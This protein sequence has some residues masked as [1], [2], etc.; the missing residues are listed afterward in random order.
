MRTFLI[1]IVLLL[2]AVAGY[3][4]T[5]DPTG[6]AKLGTD[7]VAIFQTLTSPLPASNQETTPSS[8]NV[9]TATAPVSA[10]TPVPVPPLPALPPVKAWTPPAVIPA[11]PNWTWTTQDGSSYQNVVVTKIDPETVAITHSMGVAH[12]P[13]ATLPPDIQKLLNYDPEA[14]AAARAERKRELEH[15]YYDFD[16]LAEAQAVARQLHRPLAWIDSSLADLSVVN[17]VIDSEQDLTQMAVNDLK[18][19]AIIIFLDGNA[20][21]GDLSPIIRDQQ[22]FQL[23]DGPMPGGHHF[24]GP[25]IVFSDPDITKAYGRVSF[26]QMKADREMAIDSVLATI[27]KDTA[28]PAPSSSPE[29]NA[30]VSTPA[31]V[32]PTPTPTPTPAP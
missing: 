17:P 4:Y 12:L 30:P 10:P 29:T 8:T 22:F 13:I 6:C 23:D 25:K 16:S 27:P 32:T 3:A 9:V 5:K 28:V 14:A 21:L 26:T 20:H 24:Y 11:Q 7:F 2:V 18:S 15:P 1:V 31:P 19:Q